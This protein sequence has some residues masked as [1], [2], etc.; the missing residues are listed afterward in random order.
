[1]LVLAPDVVR[2][3]KRMKIPLKKVIDQHYAN[4]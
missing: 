2:S 3:F 4:S 1:M